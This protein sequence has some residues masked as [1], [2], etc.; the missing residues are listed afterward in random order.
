MMKKVNPGALAGATGADRSIQA[1]AEDPLKLT[2]DTNSRQ[3]YETADFYRHEVA[4]L[5]SSWRVVVCKDGLQWILQRRDG[6]RA[7]ETRWT[8]IRYFRTRRALLK[9]VRAMC[10]PSDLSSAAILSELPETINEKLVI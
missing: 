6:Q 9:A 8:G 5:N 10:G 2:P 3:R 1:V 4:R 7:G